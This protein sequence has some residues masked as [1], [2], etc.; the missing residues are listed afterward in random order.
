[1]SRTSQTSIVKA[2]RRTQVAAEAAEIVLLAAAI[3][4]EIEAAAGVRAAAVDVAAVAADVEV[5][6][7]DVMAVAMV[8]TAAVVAAGTKPLATDLHGS[9]R[10][11]KPTGCNSRCGPFFVHAP[12]RALAV[13]RNELLTG[14]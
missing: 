6:A 11:L 9:S 12:M 1:M 14:N 2:A 3:A 13:C 7:V 4:V 10:I 5:A 8:D